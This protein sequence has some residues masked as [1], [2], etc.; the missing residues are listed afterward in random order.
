MMG[1]KSLDDAQQLQ[2]AWTRRRDP[3]RPR[4]D[5]VGAE[6]RGV[7]TGVRE[8]DGEYEIRSRY[9]VDC[10]G[11]RSMTRKFAGIELPAKVRS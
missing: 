8:P 10:D 9:L 4:A 3:M 5:P 11:R 7:A 1:A 6:R 2:T